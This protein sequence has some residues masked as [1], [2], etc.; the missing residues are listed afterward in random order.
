MRKN[1]ADSKTSDRMIPMVVAI[2][3]EAQAIS[4]P[5]TTCST[6]LRARKSASVRRSANTMP[7]SAATSAAAASPRSPGS[8]DAPASSTSPGTSVESAAFQP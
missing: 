2:A 8:R 7:A 1:C 3:T 6:T 4:S 5:R